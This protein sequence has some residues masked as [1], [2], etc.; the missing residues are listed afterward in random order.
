MKVVKWS[1]FKLIR[2]SQHFIFFE[3]L[4]LIKYVDFLGIR[5]FSNH[6]DQSQRIQ[7]RYIKGP[8]LPSKALLINEEQ[9]KRAFH[10]R[11]LLRLTPSSVSTKPARLQSPCKPE[12]TTSLKNETLQNMPLPIKRNLSKRKALPSGEQRNYP[13]RGTNLCTFLISLI[14]RV[15]A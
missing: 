7:D 9:P 5:E 14:H 13:T 6:L 12:Y 4:K 1:S 2:S 11:T 15:N 3:H 10:A 8:K